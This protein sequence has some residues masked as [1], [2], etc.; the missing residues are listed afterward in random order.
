MLHVLIKSE[1]QI[2]LRRISVCLS[3]LRLCFLI[4]FIGIISGNFIQLKAQ[5]N[6]THIKIVREI[7][8]VTII[9]KRISV[10][11]IRHTEDLNEPYSI[12]NFEKEKEVLKIQ[13]EYLFEDLH[14]ICNT[15][16][17]L[18][19]MS[20][21]LNKY[22]ETVEFGESTIQSINKANFEVSDE[23]M[24][25]LYAHL[26]SSYQILHNYKMANSTYNALLSYSLTDEMKT[27]LLND[28]AGN[29]LQQNNIKEAENAYLKAME[30]A[31]YQ[32]NNT[33]DNLLSIT[34]ASL[35]RLNGEYQKSLDIIE[36][37]ISN[38]LFV[39]DEPYFSDRI[40]LILI[41]NAMWSSHMLG[42]EKNAMKYG[43]IFNDLSNFEN[44]DELTLATWLLNYSIV[45]SS[46]INSDRPK[47]F[48]DI[49]EEEMADWLKR[50]NCPLETKAKV[51]NIYRN[52][53][54][55]DSDEALNT[56][57]SIASLLGQT[58][59][60]QEC[61]DI[62]TEIIGICEKTN[63]TDSGF[64]QLA[65]QLMCSLNIVSDDYWKGDAF[66]I[67]LD[68]MIVAD[69]LRSCLINKGTTYTNN[70]FWFT[71]F[72]I[73]LKY[74]NIDKAAY[75]LINHYKNQKNFISSNLLQIEDLS[76]M[77]AYWESISYS[78]LSG[79]E[80]QELWNNP[81]MRELFYD[82]ALLYKG[83]KLELFNAICDEKKKNILLNL[84]WRDV[85][86]TLR[87]GE[88][89]IEIVKELD[90]D[91]DGSH[92]KPTY[93]ALIISSNS[94]SPELRYLCAESD[95]FKYDPSEYYNSQDFTDCVFG[96]ITDFLEQ[97]QIST[98][99]F[100][101]MGEY[102]NIAIETLKFSNDER[103]SEKYNMF[104][105][106]ST[107]NLCTTNSIV[108]HGLIAFGDIDFDVN[109]SADDDNSPEN[110]TES[111]ERI[112]SFDRLRGSLRGL[113]FNRLKGTEIELDS[114]TNLCSRYNIDI[115]VHRGKNATESEFR[116]IRQ[117]N[118]NICHIATHGFFW[119]RTNNYS[120]NIVQTFF[121]D[122]APQFIEDPSMLNSGILFAGA[123]NTL[124]T[125]SIF[126]MEKD[127]IIT[128]FEISKLS[129]SNIDLMV[130]SA[131]E[132]GLGMIKG[133]GVFGLQRGFKQAGVNSIMMSLWEVDDDATQILMTEFYSNYFQGKTKRQSLLAAQKK[134]CETPGFEDPEYWAAFILLDALN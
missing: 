114:I 80:S 65:L 53:L 69:K 55:E 59:A 14:D 10:D 77:S 30:I 78:I 45:E 122:D 48:P 58:G 81:Q 1:E 84:T 6:T 56:M 38:G 22:Q 102:C 60:F 94:E 128:A 42:D 93:Y 46:Y 100:S 105:L 134:V 57:A 126:N 54:G 50:F 121:N 47:G 109:A 125:D 17:G 39:G 101:P 89:A 133:D 95:L 83:M 113:R 3:S 61:S 18:T 96:A 24:I 86:S 129:L 104:R 4:L 11:S 112:S 131:C 35:Y 98:I 26:A 87:I 110:N 66:T 44:I 117:N 106:S 123:N 118:G 107:R 73:Y 71:L 28:M 23:F 111:V 92:N 37:L 32:N 88:A 19:M 103:L 116:K 75:C 108:S 31:K 51:Y 13:E 40:K 68:I 115:T 70:V 79:V 52:A 8:P 29:F 124:L 64:Y 36:S 2:N 27:L 85:K 130:L 16:L 21:R 25:N 15:K 74:G 12:A 9:Y 63:K 132:T 20:F 120:K 41:E 33:I 5:T 97:N 34:A 43:Q 119:N 91:E 72:D 127:G 82:K 49:S 76:T 90:Y 7:D 62:C 67:S 99:Y